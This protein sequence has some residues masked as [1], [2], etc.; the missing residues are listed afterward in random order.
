MQTAEDG[1]LCDSNGVD[2]RE[3]V[4]SHIG[5]YSSRDAFGGRLHIDDSVVAAACEELTVEQHEF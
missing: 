5:G 3:R 4:M 2:W 1:W